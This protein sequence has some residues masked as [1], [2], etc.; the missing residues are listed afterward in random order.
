M[1]GLATWPDQDIVLGHGISCRPRQFFL[2]ELRAFAQ[3]TD[4][5]QVLCAPS[6]KSFH[7]SVVRLLLVYYKL[8]SH[9]ESVGRARILLSE[10]LAAG[11]TW[12]DGH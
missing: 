12:Q 1:F 6:N 10:I 3:F 2:S 7:P 5:K 9:V 8:R 4:L 11:S